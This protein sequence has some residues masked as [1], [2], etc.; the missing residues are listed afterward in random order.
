MIAAKFGRYDVCQY[1]ISKGAYTNK[2]CGYD[3]SP[4]CFAS[5]NGHF[6]IVKL[7]ISELNNVNA[8][9]Y[10]FSPF[11]SPS[12]RFIGLQN[13]DTTILSRTSL[14]LEHMLMLKE[15][16]KLQFAMHQNSVI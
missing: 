14:K 10:Q 4:L 5:K 2:R 9:I 3:Q 16:E 15:M 8:M 11:L 7:L 6:D 1:L 12:T 13:M